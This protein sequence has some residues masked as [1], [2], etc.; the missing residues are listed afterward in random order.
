MSKSVTELANIWSRI[1]TRLSESVEDKRLF[2]A[3]LNESSIHS[4]DDNEMVIAVTSN[5]AAQILSTKYINLILGAAKDVL[6]YPVTIKIDSYDNLKQ[7]TKPIPERPLFFKNSI[8][9]DSLTFDS[10]VTGP[11][12]L[13]ACQAAMLIASNPGK[14]FNPLFLYSN[15]GLG[16][17]HLLQA[18]VNYI[19]EVHPEKKAL[20]CEAGDFIQEF[21]S[22]VTG[23]SKQE[24]LKEYIKSFDVFLI[25]D[26]Q[27]LA[28][29]EQT[30]YF[31]FDI[32]NW[33]LQHNKQFV[34]ASDKHPDELKG[35]Y[36]ERIKS[37]FVQGLTISIQQPDEQTCVNIIKSK[38]SKGVLNV[39]AFDPEVFDFIAKN[40]SKNIRDVDQ[41]LHKLIFYTTSY[42]P[43]KHVDLNTAMEALQSIMDV[44]NAKGKIGEQRIINTVAEYYNITPSQIIGPS[45][46][47][48]IALARH[49]SMYLIRTMLDMPYKSIG[50]MFG[51]KDHSTVMSGVE[52]VE[53]QLKTNQNLS[54][55][56]EE[57]K[58][59]LK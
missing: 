1:K 7:V 3:F 59:R 4:F 25:D 2:D 24:E 23:E 50:M 53:K 11:N 15:P 8:V 37:R 22:Y 10:F 47:G 12:N 19:N 33:F 58:G 52:K 39:D 56:V 36:D 45:R 40:F 16:K 43:T 18:I 31:F 5:F 42:K 29:K 55:A 13:E 51:G 46:Q 27:G 32:F 38:V 21:V 49:I 20:Y 28:T 14:T 44:K 17:T 41:A 57:L 9:N 48:N 30:C 6:N 34:I 54:K 35:F 26:I